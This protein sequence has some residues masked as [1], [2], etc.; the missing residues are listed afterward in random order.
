MATT[1]REL[2]NRIAERL[3][4]KQE[5][6]KAVI[7]AFFAEMIRELAE[8]RRLE[9]RD[10]GIFDVMTKKPRIARNPRTGDPVHIPEKRVVHFKAGRLMR[11]AVMHPGTASDM[12]DP[13]GGD[14]KLPGA[15]P[16][17]S[18]HSDGHPPRE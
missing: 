3:G 6:A 10:F 14:G 15:E 13:I 2:T 1:K 11:E 8:G 7:Q 17:S 9:F 12:H 18:P 5:T 16:A 4:I